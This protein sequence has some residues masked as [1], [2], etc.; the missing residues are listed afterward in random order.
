MAT[1]VTPSRLKRNKGWGVRIDGEAESYKVG[2]V[3]TV[4]K[5]NGDTYQARLIAQLFYDDKDDMS[6][7]TIENLT[8]EKGSPP[9]EVAEVFGKLVDGIREDINNI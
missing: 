1:K 5:K 8:N 4:E 9:S 3:V 2:Q 6:L 7:W